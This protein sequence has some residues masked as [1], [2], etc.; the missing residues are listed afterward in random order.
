MEKRAALA[1]FLSLLILIAFNFYSAKK[2]P[3]K[4]EIKGREDI[5]E[6]EAV[7]PAVPEKET[8]H[9]RSGLDKPVP[10]QVQESSPHSKRHTLT[11]IP[12]E[13]DLY[14]MVL[15]GD[16]DILRLG[17]TNFR[18]EEEI[19]KGKLFSV[20]P[21]NLPFYPLEFI[22]WGKDISFQ[23]D[24]KSLVLNKENKVGKIILKGRNKEGLLVTKTFTFNNNSY[25]LDLTIRIENPS[26]QEKLVD[27]IAI[28]CSSGFSSEKK[29]SRR[30]HNVE[31]SQISV[32]GKITKFRAGKLKGKQTISET[33]WIAQ[34]SQYLLLFLKPD[35]D[36]DSF[37]Y[38][39]K[40]RTILGIDIPAF[41]VPKNSSLEK[42][43]F[44]YG[45]PADYEIARAEGKGVEKT[46][47]GGLFVTLGKFIL[48]ILTF[49]YRLVGNW[50]W[51]I[52]ILTVLVKI[53]LFP[54]SRSSFRSISQMQKL[55]PYLKDL[56]TK[57]KGNTQMMNK[58]MM[59]LYRKYKINPLGGCL[60]MLAQMPVFIAFFFALRGAVFLRGARFILW[61][62]DL[63]LPDT[64]IAI[65]DFPGGGINI[66]PLLM[67]ASM[68]I[69]QK[70]TTTDPSQKMMT[71]MMPIFFTFIFYTFPSGLL[72]YWLVMNILSI[73]E[74]RLATEKK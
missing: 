20:I 34:K 66:L 45:G 14:K 42:S 68:L 44:F 73:A 65:S 69:Q 72:L 74:Q 3:K 54:L 15:A 61:I 59:E 1:I 16:G 71:M 2:L 50:G 48:T 13:T 35:T 27:K 40:G 43:F 67:G 51:A 53:L 10:D 63:S 8:T 60:P 33:E 19:K 25:G 70:M 4:G 55:Q 30:G 31:E 26:P 18:R 58:E 64:V 56:K 23:A 36:T 12:V 39:E 46:L 5:L 62:N 22:G 37:L 52:I 7:Q 24:K 32:E 38:P 49:F 11:E 21:A 28:L 9:T 17:L 6:K 41:A 47:E 29:G 57:Y